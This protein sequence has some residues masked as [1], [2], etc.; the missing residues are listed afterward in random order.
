MES[1]EEGVGGVCQ[2][3]PDQDRQVCLVE[4]E[5]RPEDGVNGVCRVPAEADRQ[6]CP[7]EPSVAEEIFEL[8]IPPTPPPRPVHTF[9][10]R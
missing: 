8:D 4:L 10:G 1:E 2:L 3:A 7:V 9:F 5:A 6:V